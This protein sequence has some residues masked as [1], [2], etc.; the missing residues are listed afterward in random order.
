M[1]KSLL[2]EETLL[3]STKEI[4]EITTEKQEFNI[5]KTDEDKRLVFGWASIAVTAN[6]EVVTDLQKD[7]IEPEE[8]EE[9]VYNYVLEFRDTGEEHI[10]NMRK[11]GKMVESV[12]F[13]KEKMRAMGIPEGIVPEGWW[14][15]FKIED[16][17]AWRKVKDGTYRMFS[18][19]GAAIR[20]A[21]H[22]SLEKSQRVNGCGVLV[23]RDGKILT[24]TRIGGKHANQICGP[25]G[26]IEAGETYD[27]A[28]IRET[29]EEFGIECKSL[30]FLGIHDDGRNY[31]KSALFICDQFEGEPKTD[32][33]EMT[34]CRWRTIEVVTGNALCHIRCYRS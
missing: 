10:P 20:E 28:A 32:E 22:D 16:E 30:Q 19:E 24:G 25:G 4:P 15:G 6:G 11:K 21:V 23:I 33:E 27:E 7:I 8:L 12:V 29:R 13:T 18:I 17:E 26:H 9:A 1:H 5:F 34:D 14:I 3:N 2:F 31:G